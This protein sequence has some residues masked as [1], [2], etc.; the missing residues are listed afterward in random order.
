MSTL[1][2]Q[3]I[4]SLR[5]EYTLTSDQI[6]FFE[7]TLAKYSSQISKEQLLATYRTF[8]FIDSLLEADLANKFT[9]KAD[10]KDVQ[11]TYDLLPDGTIHNFTVKPW[12]EV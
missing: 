5:D 10:S 4:A 9:K 3:D 1:T 12:A 7:R 11:I 6:K 2:K 8:G